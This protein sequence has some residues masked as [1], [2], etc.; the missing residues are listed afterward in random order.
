MVVIGVL[1]LMDTIR[2]P[3]SSGHISLLKV[4]SQEG[5]RQWDQG[6]AATTVSSI[7]NHWST[8][9]NTLVSHKRVSPKR[10]TS[11]TVDFV[12]NWDAVNYYEHN[13]YGVCLQILT[14]VDQTDFGVSLL[15]LLKTLESHFRSYLSFLGAWG[16]Q[17]FVSVLWT[18]VGLLLRLFSTQKKDTVP[19]NITKI[20]ISISFWENPSIYWIL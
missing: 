18:Y 17:Q 15:F 10:V 11:I 5:R 13:W 1:F 2:S 12:K 16:P 7:W 6:I 14:G 19:F 8:Y 3:S 20:L 9:N 4:R